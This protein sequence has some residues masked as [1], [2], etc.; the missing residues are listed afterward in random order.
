[1][2]RVATFLD[3]VLRYHPA[4]PNEKECAQSKKQPKV[5]QGCLL[6]AYG[7]YVLSDVLDCW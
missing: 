4:L 7:V 5:G 3:S 1:M 6:K 2:P